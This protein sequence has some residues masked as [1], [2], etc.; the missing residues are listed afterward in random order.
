MLFIALLPF[1][2]YAV[3]LTA[4][5]Q[6]WSLGNARG[7]ALFSAYLVGLAVASLVVVPLTDRL[8]A[9]HFVIAGV[10]VLTVS[11]LSFPLFAEGATSA[12][13]LR[14]VAGCGHVSVYF[15]G[16]RL[17]SQ[18]FDSKARG[19]AVAAFVGAGYLG[20]TLSYTVTGVLLGATGS[21]RQAYGFTAAMGLCALPLAYFLCRGASSLQWKAPG[22]LSLRPLA[23]RPIVLVIAAYALHSAELYLARLWL[24]LL[25]GAYLVRHGGEASDASA[26]AAAISGLMFTTGVAGVFFGGMFSDRVGRSLAAGLL[27]AVSGACSF[28]VGWLLDAPAVLIMAVGVVYGF[29]TAADSSVYSTALTELAP[30][31]LLGSALAIQSFLGFLAGALAP[32]IA[33][34][35]LDRLSGD[36]A[37]AVAFG[38]NGLL[39]VL[40]VTALCAL[41]RRPEALSMAAGRR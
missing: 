24:P 33:G 41:R 17:V 3:V 28:A 18:R 23:E 5:Q 34:Y 37:W 21:W 1:S 27:F 40:G 35:A 26:R 6:E 15:P 32:M 38:F 22:L 20:T 7:A 39:A 11:N 16:I 9:E 2:S 29:S 19:S 10:G 25:L 13:W 36:R 4:V 31:A 30:P 8:P 12:A 14:F